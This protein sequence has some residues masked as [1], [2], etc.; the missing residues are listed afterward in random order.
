M[1]KDET[2]KTPAGHKLLIF[3]SLSSGYFHFLTDFAPQEIFHYQKPFLTRNES[4]H[5]IKEK[6]SLQ[7]GTCRASLGPVTPDWNCYSRLELLL[8]TGASDEA[9][10]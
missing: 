3:S 4:F 5:V 1:N 8:Q 9:E 2:F 7:L 6:T 10:E